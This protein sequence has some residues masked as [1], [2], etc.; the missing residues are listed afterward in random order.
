MTRARKQKHVPSGFG[1]ILRDLR[2][3]AGLTQVQLAEKAGTTG[4]TVARLERG[5]YEPSWEIVISLA[6]AL[7]VRT[8]KMKPK[9][10]ANQH[11]QAR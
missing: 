3:A 5:M 9:R 10:K 11:E 1:D 8:E 7:G 2:N 4:N 6:D